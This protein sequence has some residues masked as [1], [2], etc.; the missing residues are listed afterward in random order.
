M[1]FFFIPTNG[2]L[3]SSTKWIRI[4]N[5]KISHPQ[6]SWWESI[7]RRDWFNSRS[8]EQVLQVANYVVN[9]MKIMNRKS[10]LPLELLFLARPRAFYLRTSNSW[11][12]GSQGSWADLELE[13]RYINWWYIS[14]RVWCK[15]NSSDHYSWCSALND[16][17]WFQ[18]PFD[19]DGHREAYCG[20]NIENKCVTPCGIQGWEKTVLKDCRNRICNRSQ[21]VY[22]SWLYNDFNDVLGPRSR[23]LEIIF[24]IERMNPVRNEECGDQR[25]GKGEE[26]SGGK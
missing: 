23:T 15:S 7:R 17:G 11:L 13:A 12:C 20:K 9:I 6:Q 1:G 16:I 18:I 25:S 5:G 4:W 10:C 24:C 3:K 14:A 8:N 22:S 19:N 2:Y 26:K 21:S